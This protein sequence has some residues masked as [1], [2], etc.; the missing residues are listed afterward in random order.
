[1]KSMIV[2]VAGT[3]TR[4][5]RDTTEETLK[6]LYHRGEPSMSLLSQ[7]VGKSEGIDEIVIVGGY[8]YEKLCQFVATHLSEYASKI[9]IVYNPEYC[10]Y[11]SGY[12]LIKG[13]ENVSPEADEVI[14]VE[15]DLYFD[16]EEFAL[17]KAS[18][19]DVFTVNHELITA[20]KSVVVYERVCGCIKYLYDTS[21]KSLRID[22]PFL[23]VY[24]SGQ[25]WKFRD[26]ARLR[27]V[28]A[29]LT[30]E[31]EHGTNLEI[32]QGYFDAVSPDDYEMIA[33]SVWCNCNT[34][35]DWTK[36]FIV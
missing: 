25:I 4:F 17:I 7:I 32:V 34:V 24:N 22:E 8:L 19:R 6:C 14:F 26:V 10:T 15:G 16:K 2:T 36:T 29:S 1:M 9:R 18:E 3:A 30:P 27:G 33:L 35:A 28:V 12:S 23:A 31:Q 11:G 13:I 20:D 21:H 5:N